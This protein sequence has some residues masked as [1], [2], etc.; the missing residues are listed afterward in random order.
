MAFPKFQFIMLILHDLVELI[1]Y[2]PSYIVF[3]EVILFFDIVLKFT[4]K[5]IRLF[6]LS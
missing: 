4:H 3:K 2:S 5:K 1:T 6:N